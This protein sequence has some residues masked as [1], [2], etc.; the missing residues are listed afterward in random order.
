MAGDQLQ[1]DDLPTV[2]GSVV[3]RDGRYL[4]VQ[5]KPEP[6]YGKW[7]IPAGYMDPGET[8]KAAAVR[9]AAE[10]TGYEIE[11]I[12][13]IGRFPDTKKLRVAFRAQVVGGD[14]RVQ[15]EEILDVQWLT[16]AEIEALN[17][18]GNIRTPWI[19]EAISSVEG[20]R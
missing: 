10:A 12:E 15:P 5:A 8:E 13:E 20:D 6:A 4:M 7:G 19:F 11:I 2:A 18:A 16:Y 1:T 3:E 14:R 17:R 9:E